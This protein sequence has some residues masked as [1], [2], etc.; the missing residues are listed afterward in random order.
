MAEKV[1]P[2]MKT[3]M[4]I[5]GFLGFLALFFLFALFSFVW[6]YVV[7]DLPLW[8]VPFLYFA[9][10]SSLGSVI[11]YLVSLVLGLR[12]E[13]I[14]LTERG[15]VFRRRF[16]PVTIQ[17]VVGVKMFNERLFSDATL[18]IDGFA[19]DGNAVRMRVRKTPGT[20]LNKRWLEFTSDV[21]AYAV[22]PPPPP[23]TNLRYCGRCGS[24]N[25]VQA[26]YCTRCGQRLD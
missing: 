9:L 10:F 23:S 17:S 8:S 5:L 13:E 19:P 26:R 15:I 18:V 3:W 6:P 24:P 12:V 21:Q 2:Y 7:D 20:D 14:A 11:Y 22:S 25:N 1:Y 16:R 4:G